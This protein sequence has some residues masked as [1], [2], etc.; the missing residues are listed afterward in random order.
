[1]CSRNAQLKEKLLI[2]PPLLFPF[3]PPPLPSP[4]FL[5]FV[6]P[7][8]KKK[9]KPRQH[10]GGSSRKARKSHALAKQSRSA[11]TVDSLFFSF[12]FAAAGNKKVSAKAG[13]FS[14]KC[15]NNSD[16]CCVDG[17]PLAFHLFN[18]EECLSGSGLVKGLTRW[19]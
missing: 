5:F 6:V 4:L 19:I 7:V 18:V 9:K 12:L 15:E 1:M 3:P 8:F 14:G 17:S 2:T 11:E 13:D 16:C 10:R